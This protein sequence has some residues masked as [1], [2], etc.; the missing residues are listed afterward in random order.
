MSDESLDLF[1][2][3]PFLPDDLERLAWL[4][5]SRTDQVGPALFKALLDHY[6]TA[7]QA[8]E[9]LPDLSKRGGSRKPLK[10][11]PQQNAELELQAAAAFGASYLLL[12]EPGYPEHLATIDPPPP[13]IA[14]KGNRNISRKDTVAIV[15]ARNCSL[16]GN[17][18]AARI[19][20]QL[21]DAGFVIASG[22]AR[23]ID[24]AAHKASLRTGTVAVFAG[25]L[26]RVY[27]PE[28][29]DLV[30]AILDNGGAV[31]SEMSFGLSPRG[32]DFPRRNRIVSGMSLGVVIIEAA[33]RSGTL[34]TARFALE[35]NREIFAVP[36]SPLD[37]RSD[38]CN[39]L[40][41]QGAHLITECRHITEVLAPICG[42]KEKGSG[43]ARKR[44]KTSDVETIEPARPD[45]DHVISAL[46]K[47]PV[48]IDEL[49][50]HTGLPARTIH[51]ILLELGPC[52]PAGTAWRPAGF[53]AI[54]KF[55]F[56]LNGY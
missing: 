21:G 32:R 45:R 15:G 46:G 53:A 5:L 24:A 39:R 44:A 56:G 17:K 31:L 48:G 36:G 14:F 41:R 47:A 8:L 52:Q 30:D 7:Q 22:L 34:H 12:G 1:S 28:H 43:P 20:E 29:N 55:K 3:K 40:I 19:A 25:G 2:A 49:I 16:S 11:F 18:F 26:D 38:G 6:G 33:Q 42:H 50:R 10:I 51:L 4:R 9:M 23:G 13:I 54:L 27:P 35:Q 37:P